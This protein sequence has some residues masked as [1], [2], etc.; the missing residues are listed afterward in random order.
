MRYFGSGSKSGLNGKPRSAWPIWALLSVT[1]CLPAQKF[2]NTTK[3]EPSAAL[4]T[5]AYTDHLRPLCE[6][7]GWASKLCL[8]RYWSDV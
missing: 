6:D 1:L 8:L 5:E 2:A 7:L 4:Q 3:A